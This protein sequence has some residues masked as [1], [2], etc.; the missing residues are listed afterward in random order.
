MDL[1]NKRIAIVYDWIDKWGGVER[2][3]LTLHALFP[4]AVFYTS[5]YDEKG[6]SWAEDLTI[7]T[8]F[9]QKLPQFIKKS[10]LLSLPL[11]PYAFESFDLSEYDIVI[12]V[13][14]SFAK[15]I[16]TRPE[17]LHLCYLLTPTRYLWVYPETYN[18]GWL[19]IIKNTFAEKL[20]EWDW[21]AAQRP[22]KYVSIAHVV[23]E[24]CKTFYGRHAE[25]LYPPF[26]LDYWKNLK[27][28]VE[29]GATSVSSSVGHILNKEYYL[30]VSRLE[31]YKKVD[32][33]IKTFN[34]LP[35]KQLVIVGK[36][37]ELD[38]LQKIAKGNVTFFNTVTDEDLAIL[39]KHAQALIMPQEE[40]FGY[41]ALESQSM[42]TPVIAYPKGGA[43]E[44]VKSEET[45][46]FF[47]EQTVA[48][49]SQAL[50]RFELISYNVK[51]SLDEKREQ[52]LS[53]FSSDNFQK[54]FIN[55]INQAL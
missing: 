11:Y 34:N 53:Q 28:K 43:L 4:E 21:I 15:G 10:R 12:S 46:L 37:T 27:A 52:H 18:Q 5:Y 25:V 24:R 48:S 22:D 9:I 50:E 33:V 47:S 36:G 14:S 40:D 35:N 19:Q 16:I 3:L 42:G 38:T 39:Y 23:S 1:S 7:K 31:T 55:L 8:S 41:V 51:H 6:A 13:T 49:L 2:V 44:T 29:H 20:R 30:V 17:T 32:M 45:G 26:D 54:Q